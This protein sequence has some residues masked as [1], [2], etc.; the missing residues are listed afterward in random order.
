VYHAHLRPLTSPLAVLVDL[1]VS[2]H[3]KV[4]Q[5]IPTPSGLLRALGSAV[6]N[7]LIHS[8]LNSMANALT[9]PPIHVEHVAQA[10]CVALNSDIRGVVDVQGMRE[11]IAWRE[12]KT[13]STQHA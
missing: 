12:K 4:P 13:G 10:I 3:S 2:L 8:S 7:P 11:L 5:H 1:S 6:S 9:T